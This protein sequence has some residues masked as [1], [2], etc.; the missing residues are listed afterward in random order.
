MMGLITIRN[1]DDAHIDRERVGDGG[2][3]VATINNGDDVDTGSERGGEG[4]DHF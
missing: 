3:L 4:G 2:E 1:G